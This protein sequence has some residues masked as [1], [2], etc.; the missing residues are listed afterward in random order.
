METSPT[1]A[2]RPLRWRQI[3][4]AT[5]VV[6]VTVGLAGRATDHV[7]SDVVS[8]L[9]V[10]GAPWLLVAF[11]T[12]AAIRDRR[13]AVV[14]GALSQALAVAVYY[15]V[16]LKVEHR[17][18]RE[19]AVVMTL[20]W[21]TLAALSGGVF[22]YF[23]ALIHAR[24]SRGR[25]VALTVCCGMLI[26][27]AIFGFAVWSD[28][29]ARTVLTAELA[30]GVAALALF[31]PRGHAGR[32]VALTV[33]VALAAALAEAGIVGAMLEVGWAGGRFGA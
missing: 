11:I 9:G 2:R 17:A 28:S 15:F 1:S 13:S 30:A 4:F 24:S 33:S 7:D 14:A 22:A 18:G 8:W 3:S 20:G 26:G 29:A 27:E 12:G 16:M 6:G 23:G 5:A 25:V 19:Y 31:A 10:V 32:V 21:A